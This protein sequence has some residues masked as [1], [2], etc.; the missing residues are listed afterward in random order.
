MIRILIIMTAM[1]LLALTSCREKESKKVVYEDAVNKE[2][3]GA[4]GMLSFL[5]EIPD[6]L[7]SPEARGD[8]LTEHFWDS[9]DFSDKS[10]SL[11]T[12]FMEQGFADF[13]AIARAAGDESLRKGMREFAK[14]SAGAGVE[15]STFIAGIVEKY[16]YDPNSPMLDEEVFIILGEEFVVLPEVEETQKVRMRELLTVAKKNRPGE[17]AADFRFM[18]RTGNMM[19]LS[20]WIQP[21][22]KTLLV[23]YD[24]DC[25]SCKEII[26]GLTASQLISELQASGKMRVLAI[27][28][29]TARDKWRDGLK[30]FPPSWTVGIEEGLIE[31][32]EL[33]VFPAMPVI[34]FLDGNRYVIA[35]DLS[36]SKLM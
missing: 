26:K 35:K 24:P 9:F 4:T 22:A 6:S 25:D 8:F 30:V 12:A 33:Y 28:P 5:P 13:I 17:L 14:R 36:A 7:I 15:V 18:N 27:Y 29:G 16:L 21:D 23:F 1:A 19:K 34:Y 10:L 2:M 20:E 32:D 3:V 11:D 31:R